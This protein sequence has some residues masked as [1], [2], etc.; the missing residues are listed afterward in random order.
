MAKV[1]AVENAIKAVYW[2]M[3]I[4]GGFGYTKEYDVERW[5]GEVNLIRLA[6]ITQEMA[7]NHIGQYVVGM[8]R[9]YS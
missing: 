3:Q 4:F 6:P 7:L 9:T 1:V 5:W 8:P 2:P